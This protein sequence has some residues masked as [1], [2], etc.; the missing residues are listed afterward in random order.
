MNFLPPFLS[1]EEEEK[2]IKVYKM[3]MRDPVIYS[4]MKIHDNSAYLEDLKLGILYM[5]PLKVY[6]KMEN[7]IDGRK[8]EYEGL[9]HLFQFNNIQMQSG[10]LFFNSN[11]YIGHIKF[12]DVNMLNHYVFC[13]YSINSG[14]W[15]KIYDY[16]RSR[17]LNYLRVSKNV[18]RLGKN[19]LIITNLNVFKE[20]LMN[21][22]SAQKINARLGLVEYFNEKKHHGTFDRNKIGFIKRYKYAYQKEYRIILEKSTKDNSPFRL[23]IGDLSDICFIGKTE[24][25]NEMLRLR[26]NN[27]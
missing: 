23:N 25:L 18:Q 19:V 12:N 21:A 22:L 14:L 15:Q 6:L 8:D 27:S 2:A 11:D 1:I 17:Y 10:K 9:S 20:R 3:K 4:L 26:W 24:K 5:Q 16:E 7:P 13:L